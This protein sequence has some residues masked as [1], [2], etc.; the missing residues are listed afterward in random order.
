[1]IERPIRIKEIPFVSLIK[2]PSVWC[3]DRTTCSMCLYVKEKVWCNNSKRN[4]QFPTTKTACLLCLC[5]CCK[6]H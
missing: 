6:D 2:S 5:A 1:M 3:K 4:Y